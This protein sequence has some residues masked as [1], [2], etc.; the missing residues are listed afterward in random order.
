MENR[1]RQTNH[2]NSSLQKIVLLLL[3]VTIAAVLMLGIMLVSRMVSAP[4]A[5]VIDSPTDPVT[6]KITEP[7]TEPSTS[8]STQVSTDPV[9]DPITNPATDPVTEPITEPATEPVT[10]PAV[11]GIF[12]PESDKAGNDYLSKIVFLGDSTTYGLHAYSDLSPMQIWTPLSGTMD[13]A[14]MQNKSIA[15]PEENKHRSDWTEVRLSE[16]LKTVKPEILVVTLGTNFS[17]DFG[18]WDDARKKEYFQL[19]IKNIIN[20]VNENSPDTILVFQSIYPVIDERIEKSGSSLRSTHI[21]KRNAWLFEICK[22]S[23][24]FLLK[25]EDALKDAN[26]ALKSEYNADHLDGIHLNRAGFSAVLNYILTHT[27]K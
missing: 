18:G 15:L 11:D 22:E 25:T 26:G 14:D 9:T 2:N 10:E 24:V 19:Q 13:L 21:A 3:C 17:A 20:L 16:A 5:P 27:V 1:K 12:V 8:P 7:L 6:D 23:S 4:K